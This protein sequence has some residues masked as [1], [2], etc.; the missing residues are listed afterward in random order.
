MQHG[1]G[2]GASRVDRAVTRPSFYAVLCRFTAVTATRS[3]TVSVPLAG[4]PCHHP[5]RNR[6]PCLR[7]AVLATAVAV[8]GTVANPRLVSRAGLDALPV[9]G[10]LLLP[11]VQKA[12]QLA[13]SDSMG[14][15]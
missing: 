1:H 10:P 11:P 15:A 6:R 13:H 4:V 14:A 8:Y 9:L 3:P 12:G 5:G 7:T 2:T